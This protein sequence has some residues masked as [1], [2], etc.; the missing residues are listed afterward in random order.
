M[1]QNISV[2]KLISFQG[3]SVT[4]LKK[5]KITMLLYYMNVVTIA[6]L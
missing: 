6:L 2:R 5:H 3:R 4:I 1:Q